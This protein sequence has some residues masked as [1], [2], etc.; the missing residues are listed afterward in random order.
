MEMSSARARRL[1][2]Y[3]KLRKQPGL[4]LVSLMDIFTILV[5]F[6]LVTS[7]SSQQLPNTKDL[8]LP[9]SIAKKVPK[10]TLVIMVTNEAILVQ[11][12]Q[13]AALSQITEDPSLIISGLKKEL[14]FQSSNKRSADEE[15]NKIGFEATIMGDEAISYELVSRILA[16]CRQAN[17]TR[18]AFAANQ[19]AKSK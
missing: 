5:F 17:Y 13:V 8:R 16:T 12:R 9:P 4:N 10:D 1:E 11:G 19:K 15:P 14:D 18:I 3:H 2:R 6:L 7:S